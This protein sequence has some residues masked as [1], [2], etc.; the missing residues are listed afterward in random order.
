[1]VMVM[2]MF[3]IVLDCGMHSPVPAAAGSYFCHWT[4]SQC[5]QAVSWRCPTCLG[6]FSFFYSASHCSQCRAL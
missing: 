6:K 1:M 5:T 2:M 3:D 4:P